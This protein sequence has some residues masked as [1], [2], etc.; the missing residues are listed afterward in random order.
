[1]QSA[2][3]LV[4]DCDVYG[5]TAV[6]NHGGG[7]FLSGSGGVI[8]R[9]TIS[10]NYAV[11]Y[12]GGVHFEEPALTGYIENSIIVSN[13]SGQRA[14]G[15][16]LNG[17]GTMR[18]CLLTRNLSASGGGFYG[19]YVNYKG[20]GAGAHTCT[21]VSNTAT[22]SGGGG[23][24]GD[25]MNENCLINSVIWSNAA[26]SYFDVA[27][28]GANTN[29]FRYCCAQFTVP[30]QPNAGNI[31]SDPQFVNPAVGD[32]RLLP[33]SPCVNAGTNLPWMDAAVDL[34][35]HARLD[36]FT[37]QADMGCWEYVYRGSVISLR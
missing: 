31:S 29:A 11:F 22:L 17:G 5:N 16:M 27:A 6:G 26:A 23:Y 18:N 34:D 1:M 32:Y 35:G 30:P 15:V 8:R 10:N 20:V 36:R 28:T 13:R 3:A 14:G 19:R 24:L 7:F 9:C 21:I 12:G 2:A 33:G 4:E 37:R 25:S